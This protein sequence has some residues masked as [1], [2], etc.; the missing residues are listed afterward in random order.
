MRELVAR[1]AYQARAQLLLC[2]LDARRDAARRLTRSTRRSAR[3]RTKSV[4]P[5]TLHS[6]IRVSAPELRRRINLLWPRA[7]GYQVQASEGVRE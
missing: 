2:P 1:A 6:A 3:S 4:I 7:R 5:M